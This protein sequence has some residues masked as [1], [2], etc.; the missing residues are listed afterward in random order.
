L[1]TK[2]NLYPGHRVFVNGRSDFYGQD[3]EQKYFEVME[4]KYD[5]EQSLNRYKVDIIV[6]STKTAL[7]STIKESSH[8]HTVY[9]DKVAIVFRAIRSGRPRVNSFPPVH[10]V[11]RNSRKQ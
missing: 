2:Y 6:L 10:P 4:V 8:W 11:G 1:T 3:L 5:W 9:D 7:A